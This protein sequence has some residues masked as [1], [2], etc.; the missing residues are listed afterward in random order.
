MIRFVAAIGALALALAVAACGSPP[1]AQD[2]QASA[3]DKPPSLPSKPVT[4]T[5]LDVSGDLISTK[6]LIQNFEKANPKLVDEV[7]FLTADAPSLVGKIKAQQQSGHVDIDLVLTGND[8]LAAGLKQDM[9]VK[10]LPNLESALP[11]LDST[12][13]PVAKTMQPLAE[14]YGVI[15]R[16]GAN[17]P[18]LQYDPKQVPT[19]PATPGG[20][21]GLGEGAPEQVHLRAA[22][23]TRAPAGRS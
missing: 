12:L 8:G 3:P 4:L 2:D 23:R 19:P 5:V 15:N 22:L 11:D 18:L 17:G 16:A 1:G 7:K 13:T 14:G 21:D 6:E 9:W 10:L 20:A